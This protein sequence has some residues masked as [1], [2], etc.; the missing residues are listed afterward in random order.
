MGKRGLNIY[1]C[2]NGR[3]EGC[4]RNEYRKDGKPKYQSIY[5]NPTLRQK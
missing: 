3:W 1:H 2:K 5:A 4:Y